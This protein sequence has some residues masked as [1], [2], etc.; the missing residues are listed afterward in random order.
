MVKDELNQ[1]EK[2]F[3]SAVKAERFF[4]RYKTAI[5]GGVVAIIVVVAANAMYKANS[6][7]DIM[8][9][10]VAFNTL[11]KDAQDK[12]AMAKLKK[13]SPELYDVWMLSHAVAD[14][15]EKVLKTLMSSKTIA[16]SDLATYELA[17]ITSDASTLNSYAYKQEAIYKDLAL[18][19]SSVMLMQKNELTSAQEKLGLI[20]NDS[21][22]Y[23]I[24]R[25]L[26]HYGVK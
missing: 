23:K 5:I 13:L 22:M 17:A 14:G 24:S 3:E 11:L 7:A 9:A 2:F 10:N 18:V 8:A 6:E 16:V 19:E 25:L 4:T 26:M 15:D 21:P 20:E 1:E 12:D